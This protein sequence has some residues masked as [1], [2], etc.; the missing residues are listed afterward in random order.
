M[1]WKRENT[2]T[3]LVQFCLK[4]DGYINI[5]GSDPGVGCSAISHTWVPFCVLFFWMLS[6]SYWCWSERILHGCTEVCPSRDACWCQAHGGGGWWVY[7]KL[8]TMGCVNFSYCR[9]S[10]L[11]DS[12]TS[13]PNHV[14]SICVIYMWDHDFWRESFYLFPKLKETPLFSP[15]QL[16]V[17]WF[18][19][20]FC[21]FLVYSFADMDIFKTL[22]LMIESQ[23]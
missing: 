23:F 6:S 9:F 2:K 1:K 19:C 20:F 5:P 11:T 13:N 17:F 12:L 16:Q 8:R 4:S 10:D 7:H 21:F 15:V 14:W 22:N 18:F 3:Q